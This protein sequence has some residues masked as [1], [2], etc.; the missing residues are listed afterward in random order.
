MKKQQD[1][2][3][4]DPVRINPVDLDIDI[5]LEDVVNRYKRSGLVDCEYI[6]IIDVEDLMSLLYN[7]AVNIFEVYRYSRIPYRQYNNGS[8]H[9][10][11][12]FLHQIKYTDINNI[13]IKLCQ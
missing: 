9:P 7:L 12:T 1:F 13:K 11:I 4:K 6:R 2:D 10:Q 3:E 5:R 8:K